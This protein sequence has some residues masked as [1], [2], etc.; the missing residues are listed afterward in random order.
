[1]QKDAVHQ[2]DSGRFIQ[3]RNPLPLSI[4]LWSR[5]DMSAGPDGCWL[6]MGGLNANG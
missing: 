1:M 6:W 2:P 4:R 3:R 5:V